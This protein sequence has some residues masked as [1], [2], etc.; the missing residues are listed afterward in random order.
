V[1]TTTAKESTVQAELEIIRKQAGGVLRAA[2]V[3]EYARDPDTALHGRFTWDDNKAAHEYRLWQARVMIRVCVTVT[4]DDTI[5]IR[6]YVSL[7]ADRAEVSGGY[8]TT[9]S[10]LRNPAQR[11]ALL[12][13]AQADMDYFTQKYAGLVELAGV[14]DA[15]KK[16]RR[17]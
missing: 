1:V 16:A 14:I 11:A 13:Q 9:M 3:V 17:K 6:T 12:A 5:P 8:R 4:S 15:M 7:K 2:D 10:V